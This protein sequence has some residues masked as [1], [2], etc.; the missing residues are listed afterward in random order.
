MSI[1]CLGPVQH[2]A[3]AG[4]GC[5]RGHGGV[6]RQP[7]GPGHVLHAQGDMLGRAG[8]RIG[9]HMRQKKQG[10]PTAKGQPVPAG[11]CV[12]CMETLWH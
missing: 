3:Q 9:C 6:L 11:A 2:A 12:S 4:L 1:D 10:A 5:G 8:V 7:R